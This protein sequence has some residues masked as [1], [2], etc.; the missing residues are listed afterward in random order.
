M[1]EHTTTKKRKVQAGLAIVALSAVIIVTAVAT[2]SSSSMSMSVAASA[3]SPT[4]TTHVATATTTTATGG[5]T[6]KDGTY[7]ATG[8]YFSPGGQE[9]VKVSLSL[10][11]DIVTASKVISGAND[12][13][14]SVYQM[15]FINGY[16]LYVIGKDINTIKLSNV[17]GS[18]LTSQGFNN[19]L[20]QIEQQAKA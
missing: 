14:A 4:T 10:T 13:T 7:K 1:N 12:P 3:S 9:S 6:Y 5:T 17:S 2:S 18:S 15:S 11:K 16:K 20:K 8:S 19:A